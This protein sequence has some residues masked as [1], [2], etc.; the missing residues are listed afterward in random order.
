MADCIPNYKDAV[1]SYYR[2]E[3][4]AV[5]AVIFCVLFAITS[6]L[7]AFQLYTTRTWYLTALVVGGLC[8]SQTGRCHPFSFSELR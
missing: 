4:S 8:K 7:H 3:P 1:W 6:G 5:W 2:Y